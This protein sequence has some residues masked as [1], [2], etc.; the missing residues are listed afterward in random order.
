LI[1]A[2]GGSVQAR[3]RDDNEPGLSVLIRL[4]AA[5]AE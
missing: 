3:L 5:D 2:M 4:P 1:E